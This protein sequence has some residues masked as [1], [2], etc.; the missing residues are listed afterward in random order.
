MP[1][2]LLLGAAAAGARPQR[3]DAQLGNYALHLELLHVRFAAG[4]HHRI[5][6]QCHP[7]ALQVL[8]KQRLG[9]L[10]GGSGIDRIDRSTEQRTNHS[11]RRLETLI[12]E[13]RADHRLDG[14]G[15]HRWAP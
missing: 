5:L 12:K 8:L 13:R 4:R 7:A 10:A 9:I 3:A 15:Q 11:L 2:G 6:G 14:I 1:C